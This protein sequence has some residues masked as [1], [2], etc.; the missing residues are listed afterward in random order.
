MF[1]EATV[2]QQ[3]ELLRSWLSSVATSAAFDAIQGSCP[4]KPW[5]ALHPWLRKMRE[6]R[7]ECTDSAKYATGTWATLSR[8]LHDT[9]LGP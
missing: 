9:L 4:P 3:R 2:V 6:P 1:K 7:T 8:Y 5:P